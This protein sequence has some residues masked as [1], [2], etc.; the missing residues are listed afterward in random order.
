MAIL[1]FFRKKKTEDKFIP[2]ID[3]FNAHNICN[4][5][6]LKIS[7]GWACINLIADTIATLPI[8]ILTRDKQ[9]IEI[10]NKD[11]VLYD[12]L[13]FS[14]NEHQTK[15]DF[16]FCLYSCFVRIIWYCLY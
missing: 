5:S 10:D 3:L 1:D 7:A 16:F 15:E 2:V 9:G 8:E 6:P 11:S 14:P 12:L 4:N 13:K